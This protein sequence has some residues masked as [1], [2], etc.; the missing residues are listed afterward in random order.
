MT[1]VILCNFKLP[2]YHCILY[3]SVTHVLTSQEDK[4]RDAFQNLATEVAPLYKRLAPQ[5]YSN[6]VCA[7]QI[8]IIY[9][10]L[11]MCKPSLT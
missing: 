2:L 10:Y 3:L 4:L 8:P 1:F 5:A 7:K 9:I 6:Q 11:K